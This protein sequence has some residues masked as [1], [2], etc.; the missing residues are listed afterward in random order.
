MNGRKITEADIPL[1]Q[2][3]IEKKGCYGCFIDNCPY[4]HMS[5]KD[6]EEVQKRARKDMVNF[7]LKKMIKEM[8][9]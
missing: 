4:Y 6:N 2:I 1:L 5:C 3:I 8:L 9:E 7:T